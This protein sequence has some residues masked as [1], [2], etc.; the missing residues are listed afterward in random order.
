MLYLHESALY[1]T[2]IYAWIET[3]S[4]VHDDV[5]SQHLAAAS[6]TTETQWLMKCG[7]NDNTIN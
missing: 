1:L 2:Y 5:W 3:A 4:N 7:Y 6:G